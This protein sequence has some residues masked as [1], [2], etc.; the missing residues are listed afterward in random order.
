MCIRTRIPHD[1]KKYV[2][3]AGV[4]HSHADGRGLSDMK[5]ARQRKA[6]FINIGVYWTWYSVVQLLFLVK[7][8]VV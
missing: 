8:T 4:F 5:L 3:G 7:V 6:T 2:A 1:P